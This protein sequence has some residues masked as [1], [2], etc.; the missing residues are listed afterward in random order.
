MS[1]PLY[2]TYAHL[3]PMLAPLESYEAEMTQWCELIEQE[4]ESRSALR[5]LDL[6]SGGGHHLYHLASQLGD[7]TRCTAVDLSVEMLSRVEELVPWA[8]T[9]RHDMTALALG[10]RFPLI[11]VHDSFCY[12]T[13]PEQ[14]RALFAVVA[15]HLEPNGLALVKVDALADSFQGPYRYLTEFEGEDFDITLTHYEWDPEK[16]DHQIEVVYLFLEREGP[17]LTTREERHCLGL[18]SRDEL[19]SWALENGLSGRFVELDRWDEEREN[20]LLV[21]R[22]DQSGENFESGGIN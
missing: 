21:L 19:L 9:V 4:L 17:R 20:P 12:L 2:T 11:C 18:F 5:L 13:A 1:Y 14:V 22:A 7:Q 15:G 3:W 10:E 6:G 16:S 8:T